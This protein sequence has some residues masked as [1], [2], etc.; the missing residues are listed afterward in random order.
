MYSVT[1]SEVEPTEQFQS[2]LR[3]GNTKYDLKILYNQEKYWKWR[4][5]D[6][7]VPTDGRTTKKDLD[8][9][10]VAYRNLDLV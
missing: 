1:A 8:F 9:F 3:N 5:Q 7:P 6:S 2:T 10:H 4:T